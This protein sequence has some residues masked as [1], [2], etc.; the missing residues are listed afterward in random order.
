MTN[1]N[2]VGALYAA[3]SGHP[4]PPRGNGGELSD[5]QMEALAFTFADHLRVKGELDEAL[6]RLHLAEKL[7]AVNKIEIEGLRVEL[8]QGHTRIES[9]Q[10]ERDRAVAERAK[11]AALLSVMHTAMHEAAIEDFIKEDATQ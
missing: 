7:I 5:K 4:Q 2:D 11:L 9:Y 6:N 10:L 8:A 3:A 1:K